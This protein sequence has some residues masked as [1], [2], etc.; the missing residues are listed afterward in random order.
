MPKVQNRISQFARTPER[1]NDIMP[2]VL[3][4]LTKRWVNRKLQSVSF[5]GVGK[6]WDLAVSYHH[7]DEPVIL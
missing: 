2:N 6:L 1:Q 7:N 3:D 4:A 5:L